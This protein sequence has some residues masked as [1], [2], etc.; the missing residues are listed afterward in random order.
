M[1]AL[2]A[3]LSECGRTEIR[4]NGMAD[5]KTPTVEILAPAAEV[6]QL[7]NETL[8]ASE[9][10]AVSVRF[11]PVEA[12]PLEAERHGEY[13]VARAVIEFLLGAASSGMAY[14]VMKKLM[15]AATKKFGNDNVK[16]R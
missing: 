6:R 14:D 16:E 3:T 12:D 1:K 4:E 7:L 10:E 9:R 5:A 13:E 2:D 8:T 11:V 15:A